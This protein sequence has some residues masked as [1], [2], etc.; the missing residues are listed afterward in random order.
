MWTAVQSHL[1]SLVEILADQRPPFYLNSYP[2][3]DMFPFFSSTI[4]NFELTRLLGSTLTSGCDIAEFLSAVSKIKKHNGDSWF[5]AWN[6]QGARAEDI[7]EE[8]ARDGYRV[9]ARNAYLR[10]SNYYRA[11]HFTLI[12]PDPRILPSAERSIL[13]F[14]KAIP[15]MEGSVLKVEI[16]YEKGIDL[17]GYLYLPPPEKCLSGGR[18]APVL[19]KLCGADSTKEEMNFMF[20]DAGPQMGFAVLIF[21]GPG[22]GYVLK[23]KQVPLRP[24][25]EVC[26]SKALDHLQVLL[27][28]DPSLGLDLDR[29]AVVG[30]SMG[31]YYA[32]RAS[33]DSRIKA[34]ISIDPFFSLWEVAQTRMPQF[35]SNLWLNGWISESF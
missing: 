23:K 1:F 15:L 4:F 12:H 7:A 22:Q 5:S 14:Q 32:L 29:I 18:K 26:T 13:N 3:V 10:A 9:L 27:Q 19:V 6:E 30:A 31:A 35:G 20:G 28:K 33:T 16:P 17:P 8:A 34:C 25:F 24:D 2:A 21:E 11:S